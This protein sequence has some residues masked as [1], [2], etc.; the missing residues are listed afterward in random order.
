MTSG[1][2]IMAA[3]IVEPQSLDRIKCAQ[4]DDLELEDLIDRTRHSEAIGFYLTGEGMLKTSSGRTVT[5]FFLF[6]LLLYKT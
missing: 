2:P 6:I 5:P 1:L 3:L 4:E